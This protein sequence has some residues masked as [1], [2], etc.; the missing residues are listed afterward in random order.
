MNRR[1]G[2]AEAATRKAALLVA[3]LGSFMTPFMASSIN[4]ALPAIGREFGLGAV[5]LGWVATAFLLTAAAFLLPG[6]RLA[7]IYGRKRALAA[8]VVVY[9][10]AS[11]G[12]ALAHSGAMLIGLRVVHGIGAA[13]IFGT[14]AAIV[15]SVYPAGQRG[16]PLGIITAAVYLGS[17]LG[18]ALGGLLVERFGWRSVFVANVPL[19]VVILVSVGA[20]LRGEWAEA[21]G[22]PFDWEGS[23]LYGT[24]LAA[25][26]Y[27]FS[28][29][30]AGAG[31]ATLTAGAAGLAGFVAWELHVRHPVLDVRLFHRRPVFAFSNLAA[32]LNYSAVF[33]VG[34]LLSLY[35][36]QVAQLNARQAGLVLLSQPVMMAVC[37][38]LAGRL[39]DRV[40]PRWVASAGMA[41]SAL[42]LVLLTGLGAGTPLGYIIAALVVLGLGMGL[43]S[44]PNTNAV[45][46]CVEQRLLGVASATLGTMRLTGQMASM[47]IA[48][49][50]FSVVL[51]R[52]GVRPETQGL[53]L[54]G[55][56][57]TLGVFAGL[58]VVGLLAS[59]VRG[60]VREVTA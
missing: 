56:R 58:C 14:G 38:P 48:T 39:S 2:A 10:L 4:I 25:V 45:M 21:R 3:A 49:G 5:S 47:A 44:S 29:L 46:S 20:F 36:Q 17:S 41:A 26:A 15:T 59:L 9:T 13:L 54:R 50:V 33:A 43:F 22:E 12:C 11:V 7:D 60:R 32:L 35:L 27:G 28:R 19:G 30:P 16:R 37:S 8:G 6:G 42:S 53:F 34:F 55:M 23:G 51:G 40:E 24:S 31:W 52:A 18:P 1:R 57:I